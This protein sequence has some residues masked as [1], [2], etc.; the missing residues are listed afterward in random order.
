MPCKYSCLI[1]GKGTKNRHWKKKKRDDIINNRC[2]KTWIQPVDKKNCWDGKCIRVGLGEEVERLWFGCE[3][4]LK[5]ELLRKKWNRIIISHLSQNLGLQMDK[6]P[7]PVAL[8]QKETKRALN[9]HRSGLGKQ[10]SSHSGNKATDTSFPGL[11]P[12]QMK[13]YRQWKA[14]ESW[15]VSS[16]D[17][18][19]D[20]LASLK[21]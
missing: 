17:Q 5:N 6:G 18:P 10:D 12:P 1:F 20:R 7:Y 2:W 8:K 3:V 16:R 14:T 19:P 11:T 9:G 15:R 13:S 21:C 4:N